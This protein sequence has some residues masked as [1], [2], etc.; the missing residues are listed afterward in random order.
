MQAKLLTATGFLLIGLVIGFTIGQY[1]PSPV[2]AI[3]VV[4]GEV[5][6]IAEEDAIFRVFKT[7]EQTIETSATAVKAKLKIK[8][9]GD[10]T[11]GAIGKGAGQELEFLNNAHNSLADLQ[12]QFPCPSLAEWE[13]AGGTLTTAPPGGEFPSCDS[14]ILYDPGRCNIFWE[15]LDKQ[16]GHPIFPG[17]PFDT[18]TSRNTVIDFPW[19]G[20]IYNIIL[21]NPSNNPADYPNNC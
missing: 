4:G 17:N 2:L 21:R 1:S 9:K 3:N 5:I 18:L 13:A 19:S 12:N 11:G 6:T 7:S 16:V 8:N 20:T 10:G 14:D 15:D